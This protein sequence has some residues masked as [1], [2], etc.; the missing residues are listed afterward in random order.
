M[1][2]RPLLLLSAFVVL[3]AITV[4]SLLPPK[5]GMELP[6]NDKVGHFL[7]Y[8]TCSMNVYLLFNRW[9]KELLFSLIGIVLYGVLIEFLQGF[10]RRETS[11]YDFLANTAGVAIGVTIIT[12]FRRPITTF[13]AKIN[14]ISLNEK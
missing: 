1:E 2:K 7:A 8:G 4:L 10:V 14:V 6:T 3:I 13:L 11:L 9:K 12:L 5:S